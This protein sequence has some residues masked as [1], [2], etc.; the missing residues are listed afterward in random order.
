[1]EPGILIVEGPDHV[2]KTQFCARLSEMGAHVMKLTYRWPDHMFTYHAAAIRRAL[3]LVKQGRFVVL[4]RWWP[5]EVVYGKVY[6]KGGKFPW[7]NMLNR[8]SY[9]YNAVHLLIM[10]DSAEEYVELRSKDKKAELYDYSETRLYDEYERMWEL[11]MFRPDWMRVSRVE[12]WDDWKWVYERVRSVE[13]RLKNTQLRWLKSKPQLLGHHSTSYVVMVG[14]QRNLRKPAIPWP[15]IDYGDSSL[16]ITQA[17]H[18]AG[19]NEV[20]LAWMN[21][22]GLDGR[23]DTSFWDFQEYNYEFVALGRNASRIL[24][25]ANVP[26][27]YLH[28]PAWYRRFFASK[29]RSLVDDIKVL[30]V[31]E[32]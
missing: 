21:A 3:K 1:M 11:N 28:H 6:R 14:D 26:H 4:D 19:I 5:S 20:S 12:L 18:S 17:L 2:G 22:Y 25:K 27:D 32:T 10:P 15:F 9:T 23:V 7:L 29:G 24:T 13:R 31:W 16:Y 30:S 8:V